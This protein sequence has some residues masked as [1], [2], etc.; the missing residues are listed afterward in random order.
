MYLYYLQ[1]PE[2]GTDHLKQDKEYVVCE[3]T[4]G[5]WELK[6]AC[7]LQ[8]P[9][10]LLTP[11]VSPGLNRDTKEKNIIKMLPGEAISKIE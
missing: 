5:C 10:M 6:G 11:E 8:E 4:K 9:C 2:E 3:L 7:F 1:R